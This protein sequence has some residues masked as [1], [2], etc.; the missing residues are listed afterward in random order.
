MLKA[1]LIIAVLLG[2]AGRLAAEGGLNGITAVNSK[3]SDDYVREKLAD[4]S[5]KP[6]YYAFADGGNWGGDIKDKTI[7]TMTFSDVA[8]VIAGP[9][10]DRKYLPARDPK[11]TRLLIVVYWGTTVV[12]G[13]T[14]DSMALSRFQDAQDN[15]NQYMVSSA[16]SPGHKYVAGGA[17]ADAAMSEMTAATSILN[18]ENE[19]SNRIDFKNALMLGYD[20]P[21]LIGTEKGIYAKGT[22]WEVERDELYAEIEENR[23]FVVLMAYDF[24]T[25]WKDKKHRLLWETRFS[26]N[27]RRNAFDRALPAMA[28]YAS[29]YFGEPS[30]GLIREEIPEGHVNVGEPRLVE[31]KDGL[32]K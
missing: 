11:A 5:F 28:S 9:L 12:P 14:S 32:T 19:A 6:E 29:R 4:G 27:E 13:P 20:S 23:Y 8:H 3:V 15:L 17:A 30:H 7:D 22:A 31:Y 10:A 24:Q 21:G 2:A 25:L 26:I 16:I 1:S 18:M